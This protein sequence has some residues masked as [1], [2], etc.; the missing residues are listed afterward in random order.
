MTAYGLSP[1]FL[2]AVV[3]AQLA[4]ETGH[5]EWC[6][7]GGYGCFCRRDRPRALEA[8]AWK[9]EVKPYQRWQGHRFVGFRA[10]ARVS[11]DPDDT[12]SSAQLHLK[13]SP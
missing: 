9:G 11:R 1:R 12:F 6:V 13:L 2:D 3:K 8:S 7:A 10:R 4:G 5:I